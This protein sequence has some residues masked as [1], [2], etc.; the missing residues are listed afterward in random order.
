[1]HGGVLFGPHFRIVAA[2]ARN[3]VGIALVRGG[4]LKKAN[5]FLFDRAQPRL[6]RRVERSDLGLRW[7]LCLRKVFH[8]VRGFARTRYRRQ[9]YGRSCMEE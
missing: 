3:D 9:R 8:H 4:I 7:L 1:M 6:E 5:I 2:E